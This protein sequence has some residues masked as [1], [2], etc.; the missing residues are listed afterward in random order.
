VAVPNPGPI[1]E[2]QQESL[3][4]DPAAPKPVEAERFQ[5]GG[6]LIPGPDYRHQENPMATDPTPREKGQMPTFVQAVTAAADAL[7]AATAP[8]VNEGAARR[9]IEAAREWMALADCI[10][11]RDRGLK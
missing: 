8:M 3:P 9:K 7:T 4:R 1:R 2:Q 10:D 6:L 5:R 11:R